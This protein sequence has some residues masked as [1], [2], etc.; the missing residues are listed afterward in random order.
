MIFV[1]T[2]PP[3]TGV[4]KALAKLGFTESDFETSNA[5]IGS[6]LG[7]SFMVLLCVVP[8]LADGPKLKRD[9]TTAR[10]DIRSRFGKL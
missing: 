5:S 1:P 10:D 4:K 8:F 7:I 6:T 2:D 9:I 3:L